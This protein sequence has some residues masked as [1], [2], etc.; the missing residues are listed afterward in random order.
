MCLLQK[1]LL[2]TCETPITKS[3][4]RTDRKDFFGRS[5][6]SVLDFQDKH[7]FTRPPLSCFFQHEF[8]KQF[9]H[10]KN[11]LLLPLPRV[12]VTDCNAVYLISYPS[13]YLYCKSLL[14]QSSRTSINVSLSFNLI[15]TFLFFILDKEFNF[16]HFPFVC[17]NTDI[18]K[19]TKP[20]T[21]K[22][23]LIAS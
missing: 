13:K 8:L 4:R 2:R 19:I 7:V 14:L 1:N 21:I 20:S 16:E 6:K 22:H 11:V 23:C 18:D 12:S 3:R 15:L 5:R 10:V 9:P 17:Q